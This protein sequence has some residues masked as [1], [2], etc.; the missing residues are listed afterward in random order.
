MQSQGFAQRQVTDLAVGTDA[1]GE[2]GHEG[3]GWA[4]IARIFGQV[5][6][7]ATNDVPARGAALQ[8]ELDTAVL[9]HGLLSPRGQTGP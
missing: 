1:G 3:D 4:W 5:K 7:D 8:E 2:A 9:G 6:G